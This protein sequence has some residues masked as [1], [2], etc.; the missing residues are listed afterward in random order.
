M[1][2]SDELNDLEKIVIDKLYKSRIPRRFHKVGIGDYGLGNSSYFIDLISGS[3]EFN[4]L[5]FS[6]DFLGNNVFYKNN[7]GI[8]MVR[9][10]LWGTTISESDCMYTDPVLIE[11][12]IL[13][14]FDKLTGLKRTDK[15]NSY[16]FDIV[17]GP[18]ILCINDFSSFFNGSDMSYRVVRYV[19]DRLYDDSKFTL[20]N[21]K[22]GLV[23]IAERWGCDVEYALR[24]YAKVHGDSIE[25]WV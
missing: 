22:E 10:L 7:L 18:D 9:G 24:N 12:A 3:S 21:T 6:S 1:S 16:Y 4:E 5:K 11:N 20:I 19:L 2:N 13:W 8:G 25:G 14:S 23:D 15:E 17:R